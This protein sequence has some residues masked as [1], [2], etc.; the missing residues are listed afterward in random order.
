VRPVNLIPLDER[1]GP[2]RAGADRAPVRIYILLG[3]LGVVLLSVLALVLTNNQINSKTEDLSKVKVQEQGV[4]QVA[5]ALRPF[6]QFAQVQAARKA[7]INQVT[8][9]RFNW[10]R[11][12]RQLS[13][14]IPSNVWLLNLVGTVS[15][16]IE[17]ES[18]AGGGAATLRDKVAAP[19]IAMTGCTYSQ[20]AVARMMTRMQ[21]L[22][23]VTDVQLAK[24]AR[25]DEATAPTG[26]S[27]A[28]SS[29]AGSASEDQTDCVGSERITQFDMLIVFGG[30]PL[31]SAAGVAGAGE[32]VSN[33]NS[34]AQNAGNAQS[35]V[36]TANGA[37][38]AA[39]GGGGTP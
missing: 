3:V 13:R 28:A 8:S 30:S 26:A 32:A 16:S 9:T 23:D 5:D 35:A 21:N 19:A 18:A 24:S 39:G 31:A 1:R 15:P 2:A 38:A 20:H 37:S 22:D 25:K 29:A 4:T 11:A 27:A 6:G 7:Q 12:L 14:A 33:P 36:S 34:T 10:E 17:V